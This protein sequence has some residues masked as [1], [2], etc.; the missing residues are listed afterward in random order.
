M[1]GTSQF[2][3]KQG[4]WTQCLTP[5]LQQDSP[6]GWN[7]S[8]SEVAKTKSPQQGAKDCAEGFST[9]LQYLLKIL[10]TNQEL[11]HHTTFATK[12][13]LPLKDLSTF[14]SSQTKVVWNTK[15]NSLEKKKKKE[16]SFRKLYLVKLWEINFS[17][18]ETHIFCNKTSFGECFDIWA[19]AASS[20]DVRVSFWTAVSGG[21]TGYC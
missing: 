19:T 18:A 10:L 11:L 14:P 20:E 13:F 5:P 1:C 4:Y 6:F 8:S 12:G 7:C 3:S 2:K 15:E 21:N 16:I 9:L 17:W